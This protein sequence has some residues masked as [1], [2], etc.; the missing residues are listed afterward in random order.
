M[1]FVVYSES[2]IFSLSLYKVLTFVPALKLCRS[3]SQYTLCSL[4]I[5]VQTQ[6]RHAVQ[7]LRIYS[8][9]SDLQFGQ[10]EYSRWKRK[11]PQVIIFGLALTL[12]LSS[13][14]Y[15]PCSLLINGQTPKRQVV[16]R[17]RTYLYQ[18]NFVLN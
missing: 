10:A 6:K 5:K 18:T 2:E 9:C 17:L 1:Y 8:F 12:C 3:A 7:R 16:Q 14:Q 15:T 11:L 4:L 13:N